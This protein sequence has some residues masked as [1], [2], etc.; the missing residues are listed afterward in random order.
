MYKMLIIA[1]KEIKEILKNRSTLLLGLGFA[2]FFAVIYAQQVVKAEDASSAADGAIIYLS[3]AIALFSA[4]I[5]TGQIF[6]LEKRDGVIETLM[7]TPVSLRQIWCG[8]VIAGV[9]PAWLTAILAA[10]LLEI[11]SSVQ[12]NNLLILGWAVIFHVLVTVTVF[13]AAFTGLAG[14]GQLLLG[15][16]ENK[17]LNFV[18]F[19]PAFAALYS[20]GFAVTRSID[21]T[22][23]YILIMFGGSLLLLGLT[24]FVTRFLSRERIVTTI[25]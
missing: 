1:R 16:K 10:L 20:S 6:L 18:L 23:I 5:S 15:M 3:P 13:T 21:I 2:V 17:L 25:A 11:I 7:C 19:V 24:A 12:I 9:V 4:Y 22:W 8:K 14:F